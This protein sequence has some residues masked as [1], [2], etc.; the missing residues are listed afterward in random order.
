M[1]STKTT[2]T[3]S[4][5]SATPSAPAAKKL[6]TELPKLG[7]KTARTTLVKGFAQGQHLALNV[8]ERVAGTV[9][10]V[11]PSALKPTVDKTRQL[12]VA[13]IDLATTL[14]KNNAEFASKFAKTLVEAR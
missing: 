1:P 7:A 2:A 12:M 8:A 3:A 11:I 10:R 5:T 4:S 6:L 13:N 9:D 14:A